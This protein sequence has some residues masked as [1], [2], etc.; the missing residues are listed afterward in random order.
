MYGG[1]EPKGEQRGTQRRDQDVL[2][3]FLSD[4]SPQLASASQSSRIF[5]SSAPSRGLVLK[6]MSPWGSF[7]SQA[8]SEVLVVLKVEIREAR[9]IGLSIRSWLLK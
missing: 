7:Q 2:T 1:G 4:L 8:I 5:P 3:G 9:K 6:H